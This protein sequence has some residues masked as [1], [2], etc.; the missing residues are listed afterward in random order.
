MKKLGIITFHR[1]HNCGSIMESFAMQ[2]ITEKLG[3]DSELIN[4]S[5]PGQ[6]DMYYVFSKKKK[7]KK[8]VKNMLVSPFYK[9][10][11]RHYNDYKLFV[12]NNLKVSEGDYISEDD[13]KTIE[14]KYDIFLA[15]SD[16]IWNITI[17]DYDISYF[18]SFVNSKKKIAYAPSF[19][20]KNIM[21]YAEDPSKYIELFKKFD[22]LSIRENNGKKWLEEMTG[23]E[24]PVV[25]DPTLLVDKEE[26][27]KLEGESGI[28]GD[29]IF[30]YSPQYKEGINKF[31]KKL[32]KKYKL[33]V[34]VWNSKE[35]A[36]KHLYRF[37]FKMA[38]HQD[39]GIYLD[40]IKNAKMV[41]TTSFHG[42][43]FSTIYRKKFW[44]MKNGD[45]Y[46]EDD[47]VIT[48]LNQLKM[49]DRLI[50]PNF[51]NDEDYEKDVNYADY[52]KNL[53]EL[54]EKS[55][56]YLKKALDEK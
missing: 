36:L 10:L 29:Y 46:G 20:S 42:T 7:F 15:G 5:S 12:K 17:P 50:E 13:L 38:Y 11:I 3:Y 56:E 48:L 6:R 18:L 24:I 37:G 43:I 8:Y 23:R 21:K 22:Y 41:I 14:N 40:L 49:L 45:M 2:K 9:I 16:Q 55:L 25:L 52:D 26:Y 35:F 4:F 51:N 53:P 1:A 44:V 47:R 32:S 54:R 31:V 28:K 33:P 19:G 34:I 27:Y 39:P 30:Y